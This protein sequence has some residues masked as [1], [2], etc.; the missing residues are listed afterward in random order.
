M[1]SSDKG[2]KSSGVIVHAAGNG[3]DRLTSPTVCREGLLLGRE[4]KTVSTGT[5]C[6]SDGSALSVEGREFSGKHCAFIRL[7]PVTTFSDLFPSGTSDLFWATLSILWTTQTGDTM[8]LLGG[9][10]PSMECTRRAAL[11]AR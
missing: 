6:K 7:R 8:E 4:R 9:N 11:R 10:V 1:E 3:E 5:L 2:V